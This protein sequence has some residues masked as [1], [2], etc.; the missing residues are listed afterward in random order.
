MSGG[1]FDYAFGHVDDFAEALER[2][3]NEAD[4]PAAW[5][6]GFS[7][8]V[9]AEMRRMVAEARQFAKKMH[10]VEW[11]WSGDD[12]EDTF[13]RRMMEIELENMVQP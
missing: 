12:G 1:S 7:P 11:L 9:V 6:P 10:A 5:N 13:L 3:L 8:E 4:D 2:K